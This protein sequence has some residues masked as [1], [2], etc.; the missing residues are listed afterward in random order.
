[1]GLLRAVVGNLNSAKCQKQIFNHCSMHPLRT[2]YG[3]H[4]KLGNKGE[5]FNYL[6]SKRLIIDYP[7]ISR[8]R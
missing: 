8:G 2:C 7:T 6:F 3:K 5:H 4:N 1:M